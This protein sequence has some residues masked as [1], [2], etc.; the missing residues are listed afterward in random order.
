M[1]NICQAQWLMP[2]I[3]AL[4]R[5]GWDCPEFEA[6]LGYTV[7]V[8]YWLQTETQ[9]QKHNNK[10]FGYEVSGKR[11]GNPEAQDPPEP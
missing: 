5:L 9:D 4:R 2:T 11:T 8:Q 10:T 6:G 3:L 7:L 1:E